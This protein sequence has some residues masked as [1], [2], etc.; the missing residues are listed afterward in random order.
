MLDLVP[1]CK[2]VI[3]TAPTLSIGNGPY[4]ARSIGAFTS[5]EITGE[6]LQASLA[7]TSSAD[8]MIRAGSFGI[9]DVRMAVRTAD[10]A[11]ILVQ[12]S[13]RL[14]LSN[15]KAGYT[16]VV[17]PVFETGDE[18]YAWLNRLQAI[19]KGRLVASATSARLDYD[20]YEVR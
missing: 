10:D 19:G 17:A 8:W 20:F 6:R 16:A 7:G 4:G 13:G 12:Y 1:L 5:A 14:D 11:L 2:L 15:P 18:R 9:I 3:E